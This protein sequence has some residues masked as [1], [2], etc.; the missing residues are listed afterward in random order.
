MQTGCWAVGL[1]EEGGEERAHVWPEFLCSGQADSGGLWD[2]FHLVPG[3]GIWLYEATNPTQ[4]GIDKRQPLIPGSQSPA[5]H[6]GYSRGDE[7][8]IGAPEVT[9]SPRGERK[10][11]EGERFPRRQES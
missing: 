6:T 9:L 2:A 11:A 4:W 8:T 1:G 7:N 3:V 5:S 10:R